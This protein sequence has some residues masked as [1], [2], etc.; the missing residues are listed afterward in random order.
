RGHFLF[1]ESTEAG[2]GVLRN[3]P[4]E[5]IQRNYA[6]YVTGDLI[7]RVQEKPKVVDTDLCGLGFYFL[8]RRIFDAIRETPPSALR[9]EVELTDAL[10][11]MINSGVRL[12]PVVLDGDYVNVTYQSDMEVVRRLLDQG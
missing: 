3:A 10:Q 11:T 5:Q 7:V 6:V 12:R 4:A 2:V 8:N 1:P 9:N